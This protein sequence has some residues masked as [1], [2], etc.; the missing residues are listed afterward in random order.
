MYLELEQWH[1]QHF[2]TSTMVLGTRLSHNLTR[3]LAIYSSS[4]SAT[5]SASCSSSSL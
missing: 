2:K 4:S 3:Q 1:L 5:S